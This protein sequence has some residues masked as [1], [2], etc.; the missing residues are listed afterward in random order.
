MTHNIS[1]INGLPTNITD[2]NT[3]VSFIINAY[4]FTQGNYT[5][6]VLIA[7]NSN[8][9]G[10]LNGGFDSLGNNRVNFTYV[11]I[12]VIIDNVAPKS[13]LLLAPNISRNF[14]DVSSIQ[15]G[16]N[17]TDSMS[18]N[19]TRGNSLNCSLYIQGNGTVLTYVNHSIVIWNSTD[20]QP[21]YWFNV[22]S[23]SID[24]GYHVWNV[25]C[26]DYNNNV[27][28]TA[29]WDGVIGGSNGIGGSGGYFNLADTI[30]PTTSAPTLSASS[31]TEGGSVT[32]TCTGTDS[33]TANPT[34]KISIRG[35]LNANWQEGIGTSPYTFTGTND[36]GTY[37]SKC[38]SI[39]TAGMQGGPSAETTF[40]VTK[41]AGSSQTSSGSSG[42]TTGPIVSVNVFAGQTKD[43][44]AIADGTGIINAYQASTV[45]FSVTT[46]SGGTTASS[47]SIK[48]DE[49]SYIE[50][51]ATVTISSD[52][53]TLTLNVGDVKE[54]DVDSDG[55]NDLEV[56]LKSI[57][58]NGQVNLVVRDISVLPSEEA[59][60]GTTST[61]EE[62][63]VG[64]SW[65][66]WVLI[67]IVIVVIIALLL[68]KKKR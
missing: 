49:V 3:S 66:W 53:I 51:T 9:S 47:H 5:F 19:S 10:N 24:S 15:F 6:T 25:S 45:M 16:F 2:Y 11:N 35:P 31:V 38:Y 52:P 13:L 22:S 36:V 30:G 34:E 68:P 29:R 41:S 43:L 26:A 54:V 64:M 7:N 48:F 27:N 28:R 60:E 12:S 32:I 65:I 17:V 37:T 44:G 21:T 61:T 57:D 42:G 55:T 63:K 46:S 40:A 23:T 50:G 18:G 59:T 62:A 39:D 56:N 8:V 33:I 14:S 58:E 67:V 1:L 4:N 20:Y